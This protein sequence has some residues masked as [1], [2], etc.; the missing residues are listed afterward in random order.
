M[1]AGGGRSVGVKGQPF[2]EQRGDMGSSFGGSLISERAS[3]KLS[4]YW[5][6]SASGT[7]EFDLTVPLNL[8]MAHC[9]NCSSVISAVG[10]IS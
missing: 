9:S 6:L 2:L 10:G 7:E 1:S 4:Q 8:S 3:L 5:T